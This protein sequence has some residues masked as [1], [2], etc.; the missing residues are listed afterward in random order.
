MRQN[1]RGWTLLS[2]FFKIKYNPIWNEWSSYNI[3]CIGF[4]M[5]KNQRISR[6]NRGVALPPFILSISSKHDDMI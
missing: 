5:N 3:A 4:K 2:I 6:M 1:E